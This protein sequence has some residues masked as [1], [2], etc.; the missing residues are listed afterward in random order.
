[1]LK[2]SHYKDPAL[3]QTARNVTP[4]E[5]TE[6]LDK[7]VAEMATL[8]YS[9]NGVG[10]AAPQVGDSRRI[11]VADVGYVV[12]GHYGTDLVKM[13]NPEVISYS[14][15][16]VTAEEGCLTYPGLAV[17]VARPVAIRVKFLTPTGAEQERIFKDWQARII[18][19]EI[20][21]L[22]GDTLYTRASSFAKKR[23]DQRVKKGK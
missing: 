21:H 16:T 2:I 14:A 22:N 5:I 15:E 1:M 13:V 8:M 23:Y 6:E 10:L 18:M 12:G 9:L 20:S 17:H 4:E 3:Y 19:H 7:H 11:I